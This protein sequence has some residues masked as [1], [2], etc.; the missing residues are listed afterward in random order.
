MNKLDN[1]QVL[2]QST[3][4]DKFGGPSQK[5]NEEDSEEIQRAIEQIKSNPQI[6]PKEVQ[7]NR[8]LKF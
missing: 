6:K 5:V 1:L 7:C 4:E 2:I 8:K 3:K